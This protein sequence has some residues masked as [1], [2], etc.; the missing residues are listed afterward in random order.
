MIH[1]IFKLTLSFWIV[2]WMVAGTSGAT[3]AQLPGPEVPLRLRVGTFDPRSTTLD[4]PTGLQRA[5]SGEAGLWIVQFTGPIEEAWYTALTE[6]G[7]DVVAYIPDYA[8]LVWGNAT[9]AEQAQTAPPLRWA[10]VY[11]PY[12]ALH[13][14]LTSPQSETVDVLVQVFAH[15]DA[16]KTLQAIQEKA[17]E[18][19]RSPYPVLR[20]HNLGVRVA[21]DQLAWLAAFPDVVSVEPLPRYQKLDEIQGQILAGYLTTNGSQPSGPGYL[22]WLTG[23]VGFT[24]TAAAYPIVEIVDDGVDNGTAT[25]NHPDFYEFGDNTR[26]DRLIYNHNWTSDPLADGIGGHGNLNAGLVGG[27]NQGA[28]PAYEDA[29]GYNYGLGVNP[30]GR[31]AGSKIF[32][33]AGPY[34]A[35]A[36]TTMLST[37]YN[38][39][40]RISSNSWGEDVGAG[41]YLADDQEY[42]ALVRDANPAT[43]GN[44]E[45]IVVFAAGNSGASGA[46]TVGSPANAKNVIS[47][48]AAENYRPTW[49]DGCGY[50]PAGANNA[51][52][53]ASFSGRGPTDDGRVKPDL[54]A[55]GTHI[56]GPATQT[57]GYTGEYVCDKYYPPGQTLYAASSGTSHATPAISGA[58]SLLY[59]YYQD[60]FGAVPSPAM[61]KAYLINSTRY[62]LG[63]SAG[64]TLPSNNQG[65]GEANLGMAFDGVS[66]I[67]ADQHTLLS[68]S[69]SVYTLAGG[70]GD[71]A[72]PLRVT[73]AW[74]DAPGALSGAAYVNNLDLEVAIGGQTYLGNVFAGPD[75]ITGGNPDP[76]NNVES[77]VLPTGLSGTF[78]ITVKATNIAGDGVPGNGDFTDQDFALVCYNC[79][80]LEDFTLDVAPTQQEIC[81]PTPAIFTLTTTAMMGFN[82][83]LALHIANPP[84]GSAVLIAPNPVQV[85]HTAQITLSN[86]GAITSGQYDL[87]IVAMAPARTHTATVE[88]DV[89]NGAP[90]ATALVAPPH[91]A[92]NTTVHPTLIWKSNAAAMRYTLAVAGDAGFTAAI[93]TATLAATSGVSLQHTLPVTLEYNT[94]YYWRVLA[95]NV[96]GD[97]ATSPTFQFTTHAQPATYCADP[98]LPIPDNNPAGMTSTLT[99][100]ELGALLDLDVI[101]S[102]THTWVGDLTFRLEHLEDGTRATLVDRP[103]R[104]STGIGCGGDHM[105]VRLDDD[106]GLSIED[107]C[108]PSGLAYTAG[109]AYRPNE[110]LATFNRR[111]SGGTWILRGWDQ[112]NLDFGALQRWCLIAIPQQNSVAFVSEYYTAT[113]GAT[114]A[115]ITVTLNAPAIL[116]V[117]VAYATHDATAIAGTDYLSASGLLTFSP[118]ALTG[119]FEVPLLDSASHTGNKHLYLTLT[120]PEGTVSVLP[121]TARLTI[122]DVAANTY[123]PLILRL[124]VPIPLASVLTPYDT[125]S[126]D[127]N[128]PS[129]WATNYGKAPEIIVASDGVG[130]DVLAQDYNPETAWSAVLLHIVP[131][132]GGGYRVSQ[133][134]TGIPMLDRV[135]GLGNDDAGNRYYA[136]GV[137]EDDAVNPTYPPTDT[138]RSDIVRVIKVNRAGAVQFNVDLDI[139]RHAYDPDAEMIINPMVAATSRLAVGGNEI[140]L[141]HGINTDPDWK[142]NGTR[143]QKALSTRLS[144]SDGAILR[145]SSVWVSHSFD[146][147]LLYDGAGIIEHHLGDAYPRYIVFARN[148]TAYPLFQIKGALGENNTYTRLGNIALIENDPPY[149]YLA[150]FATENSA[151]TGYAINGPRNLAIVRVNGGDNSLDP[152]LPD[153]LTVTSKGVQYT[154]RLKWL[155]GYSAG[156]NLH[157]ERPKLIGIGEDRYIVLWEEWLYT[158]SYNDTFHGVYGMVIDSNGN[159]LRGATLLTAQQHLHRGDDAFLLDGRAAWMT[160]DAEAPALYIHFVDAALIYEM[161]TVE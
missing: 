73:L 99:L 124:D 21:A 89:Y 69:G 96:C 120:H 121:Q 136:T 28:G 22:Q 85:G 4:A 137:D 20:Y 139:A 46:N 93:Y 103:G 127:L 32:Q 63:T 148:H 128:G 104:A 126:N 100:P 159:T 19:L 135:M 18:I 68:A 143:H 31:I 82:D 58:A 86:T 92:I 13:P 83:T 60:H 59:R 72:Q 38:N 71:P 77:I 156:S 49:S 125:N 26:S 51:Q 133:A 8:Y 5:G 45:M 2:L 113:R 12:Y 35:P 9:A 76:R 114:G 43:P 10:G 107:D 129:S 14:A 16:G 155:T 140:A 74:S 110:P 24:T 70:V 87:A 116:T 160:G 55:P 134:L 157:A 144:A 41:G 54:V 150:L 1:R 78:T 84:A 118:G 39:G 25:P 130:L 80:S 29:N 65:Y 153:S 40:A 109:A 90:A 158:G 53:I 64:D 131:A 79:V 138:Y 112:N 36:Y 7:L 34:E 23:T 56:I 50:G 145:A 61:I 161:A 91:G 95:G 101:I 33:N 105:N 102:A 94:T 147:R 151:E 115:P 98:L 142:I 97:G 117:T 37:S 6:T 15:A 75:S 67:V 47:V 44:Q 57:A 108:R 30:F 149:Q 111:P 81:A 62:L 66:R 11:Q 141:V 152:N 88:L 27:Y 106:A 123:L 119:T 3:L 122:L 132:V 48:G 146:Q 42:D 52:D 154:N 17:L